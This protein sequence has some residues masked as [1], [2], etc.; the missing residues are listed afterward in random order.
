MR[1]G[2][3]SWDGIEK[4]AWLFTCSESLED[5]QCEMAS[6]YQRDWQN[7]CQAALSLH[8]WKPELKMQR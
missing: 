7:C 4:S 3:L 2:E 6:E 1:M 8:D 5:G